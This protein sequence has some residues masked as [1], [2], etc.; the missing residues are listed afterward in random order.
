MKEPKIIHVP[1]RFVS[2]EWGGTETVI[3]EISKQQ[4]EQGW[5]PQIMTSMALAHKACDRERIEGIPVLRYPH[6]YPFWGL[7]EAD[8]AAMDKK[9]GNLISW[10]LFK[11]MCQE[12][13]VRLYHAHAL[14][15]LGGMVRTAARWNQ[16]PYVIS[17][18][19][20]IFD[21]PQA[22][23]ADLTK[24][25]Q[26]KFEWGKPLG[27]LLGARRVLED[28][29]HVI[30]VGESESVKARDQLNH[31]RV[32]YLPNGVDTAR[33]A[34][35]DGGAFRKRW[36]IGPE[37]FLVVN[38]GRIDAQKN[39]LGLVRGFARMR[40]K[41]PAA[42]LLLIGPVT[43]PSYLHQIHE[44]IVAE[45]LEDSVLVI[46]GLDHG[47]SSVVDAYHA[48]DVFVLASRHEPFGIV[49]LEAW[50]AGRAVIASRVGG[51][52]SLVRDHDTGIFFDPDAED[53]DEQLGHALL[54]LHDDPATRLR[55]SEAGKKEAIEHYEWSRIAQRL[56]LI[57]EQAEDHVKSRKEKR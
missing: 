34:T 54:R 4:Q 35:G 5:K 15:R 22:E 39:Q 45:C 31:G 38:M 47:S 49:V 29:D 8:R 52:K 3:L 16:K 21:V 51:L 36:G 37:V 32:S 13:E 42:K 18:H 56:E 33:F 20:G 41:V 23:L 53:A 19:G 40:A 7:A 14:K 43:Q 6:I 12:K 10:S 9:G 26:G 17:L 27:A 48:A 50:S 57:Y 46:P 28:A 25:I 44:L 30:C 24:P 2:H 1:R 11:A 55:I